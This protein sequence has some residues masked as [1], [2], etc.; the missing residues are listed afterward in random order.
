MFGETSDENEYED[1]TY[2]MRRFQKIMR[3]HKGLQKAGNSN[4]AAIANHLFHK[5]G[6]PWY[7]T[8]DFP[9]HK[10][11]HKD[12]LRFGG[13]KYKRRNQSLIITGEKL[14]LTMS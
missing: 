6:K 8:I 3:K 10:V 5:L 11:E 4:R 13:Y 2:L 7:F 9:M 14:Q 12:Y 1:M